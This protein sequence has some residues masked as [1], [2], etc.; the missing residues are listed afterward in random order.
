MSGKAGG[1]A[2]SRSNGTSSSGNPTVKL[3]ESCKRCACSKIKC[4]KEKPTCARC[5]LKGMACEYA[6]SRRTGRTSRPQVQVQVQVPQQSEEACDDDTVVPSSNLDANS[7]PSPSPVDDGPL[8]TVM[9]GTDVDN[10]NRVYRGSSSSINVRTISNSEGSISSL[11]RPDTATTSDTSPLQSLATPSVETDELQLWSLTSRETNIGELLG[12]AELLNHFISSPLQ[13]D[14][15]LPGGDGSI[16]INTNDALGSWFDSLTGSPSLLLDLGPLE[17]PDKQN[18]RNSSGID[19]ASPW[20][21]HVPQ[22]AAIVTSTTTTSITPPTPAE[23][24][25]ACCLT[26]AVA[27]LTQLFPN[28]STACQQ[29]SHPGSDQSEGLYTIEAVISQNKQTMELVDSMLECRCSHDE[30]IITLI[31]LI[32]LKVLGWYEVAATEANQDEQ[33]HHHHRNHKYHH[34]HQPCPTY[35]APPT[36]APSLVLQERVMGVPADSDAVVDQARMA[37]QQV[38]SELHRVRRLVNVLARKLNDIRLRAARKSEDGEAGKASR[39][40]NGCGDPREESVAVTRTSPLSAPTF[41]Q[42][43]KDLRGRMRAVSSKTINFLRRA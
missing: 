15:S 42:L 22:E 41:V 12:S 11:S 36:P 31:S 4:S 3:R 10:I 5:A 2:K 43:E 26:K 7:H 39:G 35:Y 32:V 30:Y 17:F 8:D 33:N 20:V 9:H 25:T 1:P 37:A 40:S 14:S 27:L 6:V 16:N 34:H 13:A 28:A 38:L 24:S 21:V 18:S 19:V 29:T 23:S